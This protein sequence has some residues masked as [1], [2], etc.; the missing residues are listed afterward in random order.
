VFSYHPP[1][2]CAFSLRLSPFSSCRRVLLPQCEERLSAAEAT[3]QQAAA[4]TERLAREQAA[5]AEEAAARLAEAK[6]ALDATLK[7]GPRPMAGNMHDSQE[8]REDK[9]EAECRQSRAR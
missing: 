7:V 8:R 2:I 6:G 4:E 5:A 9:E 3:L 1:A